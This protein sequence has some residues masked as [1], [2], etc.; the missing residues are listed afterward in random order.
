MTLFDTLVE[1]WGGRAAFLSVLGEQRLNGHIPVAELE[2]LI[3]WDSLGDLLLSHRLGPPHLRVVETAGKP[4]A[5]ARYMD[6]SS[7]PR[8]KTVP[9]VQ[10]DKLRGVLE[11]G[12][13]LVLDSVDEMLPAVGDAANQLSEVVGEPVQCHV[14]AT[15]GSTPAF[16][17]HW[18]VLD[19]SP[20]SAPGLRWPRR[21]TPTTPDRR[22]PC[23]PACWSPGTP[24]ICP[25]GGGTAC[26]VR[27]APACT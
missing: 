2:A 23:G 16:S 27:A 22:S 19:T 1:Q 24:F 18:D 11:R 10:A 25:A 15:C 13:T 8:R 12:A 4:V 20:D 5:P 14:Y 26:R 3:S 21:P 17:P 6:G 9:I 7:S